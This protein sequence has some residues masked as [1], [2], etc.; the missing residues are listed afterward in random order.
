MA[1]PW[2]CSDHG[3]DLVLRRNLL[4]LHHLLDCVR[5]VA[6]VVLD[7]IGVVSFE[8]EMLPGEAWG[9]LVD[10]AA[11]ERLMEAAFWQPGPPPPTKKRSSVAPLYRQ[12]RGAPGE[13]GEADD[14]DGSEA[15]CAICLAGLDVGRHRVRELR[16][17]SHTFHAACIESWIA[18]EEAGTCPLC[19]TPTLPAAWSGWP[20][21]VPRTS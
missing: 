6:A 8:G 5:F 18:G 10:T 17:C 9:E 12:R 20:E 16:K 21:A 13:D 7:R 1:H 19:R 14:E 4:A 3:Y 2:P 15:I 11:M